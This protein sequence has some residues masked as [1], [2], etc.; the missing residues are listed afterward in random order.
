[1]K[2]EAVIYEKKEH[3]AFI[4]LNRPNKRNALNTETVK[5]LRR[6]WTDIESD[7]DMRVSIL[8]GSGGAFC[9]GMD[10][11]D[12]NVE[13]ILTSCIPNYGIEVT[14]PVIGAINGWAVGVGLGLAMNCDIK[15]MSKKAKLVFPE[16]KVGISQGGVDFLKYMPYAIAM[17]LWLTGEPLEAERA[18]E[19]GIV[20]RVVPDEE[21]MN[22]AIKFADL[23]KGNAPLTLKMLKL[24]AIEHTL[25]V[26]SAWHRMASRYIKPQLESEDRK[27][28][29]K[30]FL[31]KRKPVF[32]GR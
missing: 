29:I 20:N 10:L 15:V 4:K 26:N 6:A 16:A 28:G 24:C 3:V 30:A 18:H 5:Q 8:T 11:Q 2:E 31:E 14:K 23:I 22:E 21:L 25:T 12:L 9:A 32:K 1:M 17:E 13:P 27:E 7:P 19:L